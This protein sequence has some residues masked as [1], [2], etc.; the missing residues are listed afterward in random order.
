MLKKIFKYFLILILT[1][2]YT[3]FLNAKVVEDK[4]FI[5]A[6]FSLKGENLSQSTLYQNHYNRVIKQI[7][8]SDGV[9]VGKKKYLFEIIPYDNESNIPRYNSLI[10]R[11]VQ[12]DGV[13]FLIG[14]NE[15]KLSEETINLLNET[16]TV[17][18]TSYDAIS[19]YKDLFEKLKTVNS[20]KIRKHLLNNQ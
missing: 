1:S 8:S 7:N 9:K 13:Q 14:S 17:I 6:T 3:S 5:G 12:N 19:N 20:K 2:F 10:K 18:I 16:D 4:I 15:F 11:L